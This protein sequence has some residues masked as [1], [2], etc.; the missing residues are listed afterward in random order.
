MQGRRDRQR[1]E[2]ESDAERGGE[3][4]GDGDETRRSSRGGGYRLGLMR[5]W[6]YK[7]L[8]TAIMVGNRSE[9]SDR[10]RSEIRRKLNIF[11]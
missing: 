10:N 4:D 5:F 3:I 9:N 8:P 2:G 6:I 7:T 1:T 11:F